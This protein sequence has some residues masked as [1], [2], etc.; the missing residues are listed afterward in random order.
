LYTDIFFTGKADVKTMNKSKNKSA[1]VSVVITVY[2]GETFLAEC[3]ESVFSQT[4]H[5][6]EVIVVD[7]GSTDRSLEIAK[8]FLGVKHIVRQKNKDVSAARNAGVEKAC[9]D[10]IAFI[11]HDDKWMPDKLA[12]QMGV[13][14]KES[15]ADLVFCDLIKFFPSGKTHHAS[16]KH[17]IALSLTDD[18]LFSMLVRKN[19]LMPSAVLVKKKS[20]LKAGKFDE[21]FKTCGDYE[22][23]IRM[24]EMG[25]KFRYL[26][27]AL[28]HYRQ[29]TE[30]ASKKVETMHRD[31]LRAIKK[32]F[33]SPGLSPKNKAMEPL[34]LAFAYMEGAHSFF[35]IK[36]Y[37]K[38]LENARKAYAYSKRV[39]NWKFI[40]RY[41][42]CLLYEYLGKK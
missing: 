16:D 13:F 30:N 2:N 5:P 26:P 25:M 8:T 15:M 11:D 29:H 40:K 39:V 33:S 27:E 18:N 38:F 6:M 23:W 20:F 17:R 37:S 14:Q 9:G 35:S 42:R 34:G 22:M 1:L 10:F 28:T 32:I 41:I 24:A 36:Q 31:R 3:L 19:V 7:D 4:Y 12:K 21:S